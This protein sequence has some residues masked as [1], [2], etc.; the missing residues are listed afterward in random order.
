MYDV[1]SVYFHQTVL[2]VPKTD[3]TSDFNFAKKW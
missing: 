1:L 2:R 3:N